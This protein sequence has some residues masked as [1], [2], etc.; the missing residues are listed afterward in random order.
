MCSDADHRSAIRRLIPLSLTLCFLG[1]FASGFATEEAELPDRCN[2]ADPAFTSIADPVADE[3]MAQ[4]LSLL[5]EQLKD[6][7]WAQ[8]CRLPSFGVQV[9]AGRGARHYDKYDQHFLA[10]AWF[11][12]IQLKGEA[13]AEEVGK[14]AYLMKSMSWYESKLGYASGF[15]NRERGG[16]LRFP[17]QAAGFVDTEDVMQ[18]GNPADL[19]IHEKVE[20][21]IA[22]RYKSAKILAKQVPKTYT[23]RNISGAQSIFYGTGWF[24]Y[25]YLTAGRVPREGVRRYNGNTS[26]DAW[27]GK[28]HR[29]NYA[30][31]VTLLFKTGVARSPAS[32]E[33]QVLVKP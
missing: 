32:G 31:S 13:T 27:N 12:Y 14:V 19:P 6:P 10:A 24:A 23:H 20:E 28:E 16:K 33:E 3:S 17:L 21:M 1:S 11:W 2:R 30:D 7:E 8:H 25:K 26:V 9:V 29:D 15:T 18:V 5:P 22:L 4:L